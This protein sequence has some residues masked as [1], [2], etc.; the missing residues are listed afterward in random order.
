MCVN[1]SS[2]QKLCLRKI[3]LN[4]SNKGLNQ[5]PFDKIKILSDAL[6]SASILLGTHFVWFDTTRPAQ[7]S[8]DLTPSHRHRFIISDLFM[9]ADS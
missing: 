9:D 5:E 7:L 1:T 6:L 3:V 4:W 8:P 2:I